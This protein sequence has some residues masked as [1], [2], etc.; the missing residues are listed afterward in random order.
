M[1]MM[2]GDQGLSTGEM[3]HA[4]WEKQQK[5]AQG[6]VAQG[7]VKE[8]VDTDK[9]FAS[10][11]AGE[12][13]NSGPDPG[14]KPPPPLEIPGELPRTASPCPDGPGTCTYVQVTSTSIS[15]EMIDPP[16]S[17]G[18]EQAFETASNIML[19][20]G[21]AR[22][23]AFKFRN[24]F[25]SSGVRTQARNLAEQLT[26]KEAQA[27]AGGRIMQGA[28]KDPKYPEHLWAKIQHVHRLPNGKNIV[29]HYWQRTDGYREGFKFV[30]K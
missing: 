16:I 4:V 1:A 8:K 20:Q 10:T 5:K 18:P 24:L 23:F 12:G 15:L 6:G 2:T 29:I 17:N 7:R 28:I 22:N 13:I 3:R 25:V 14:L 27:G 9:I 11:G 26:L 21:L 30:N 19:F